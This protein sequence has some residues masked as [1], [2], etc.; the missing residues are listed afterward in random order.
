MSSLIPH[1]FLLRVAHP[2]PCVKAMPANAEE[3]DQLVDLPES[4]R[5]R[6]YAELD[7]KTNFADVRLAW[8]DFGLGV[9]A[10]VKGKENP[11]AGEADRPRSADG[12]TL[13][14]DTRD[15]RTSHRASR[16]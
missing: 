11:P 5:L 2:C 6:N 13:W 3:A 7:G 9:Q 4:A 12:L 14:I 15:A 8:N 10:T 1:R 16:Y